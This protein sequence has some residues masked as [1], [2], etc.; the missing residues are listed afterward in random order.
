[1]E[2]T[3][4]TLDLSQAYQQIM[5]KAESQKYVTIN[6][7]RGLYQYVRLPFGI[8]SAPAL[9]QQ[10]MNTVLE[11]IP[12]VIC[13]I[14]DILV[15]GTND[16]NHVQ[17]LATVLEHLEKLGLRL[18]KEKFSFLQKSVEYLGHKIDGKGLHALLSKIRAMTKAPTPRNVTELRAFLGL[19]S[20][21]RKFIPNLSILV[22]PL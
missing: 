2:K 17:N 15:T 22:H 8:A 1:M 21:Y 4:T 20:Y 16:A 11:G 13:Y 10:L 19:L 18:K 12:H 6:T 5:L 7:H 9:F 14:D 3:F